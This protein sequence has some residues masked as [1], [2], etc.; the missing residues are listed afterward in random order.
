MDIKTINVEVSNADREHI[1][2]YELTG[3]TQD[4]I[5]AVKRFLYAIDYRNANTIRIME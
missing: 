2:T 5:N 3:F 4:Q 1:K